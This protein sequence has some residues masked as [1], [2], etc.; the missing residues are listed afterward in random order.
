MLLN[1]CG[2]SSSYFHPD[3]FPTTRSDI[4][5]GSA[6]VSTEYPS[7]MASTSFISNGQVPFPAH[8]SSRLWPHSNVLNSTVTLP[9]STGL[10]HD[11]LSM[12]RRRP[13]KLQK[14]NRML[15]IT[16][17]AARHRPSSASLTVHGS[18]PNRNFAGKQEY[19]SSAFPSTFPVAMITSS[20]PP[21][22]HRKLTKK[23]SPQLPSVPNPSQSDVPPPVPPK[24]ISL[25]KNKNVTISMILPLHFPDRVFRN[26]PFLPFLFLPR[27]NLRQII[28]LTVQFLH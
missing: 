17:S 19:S 16:Q 12:D 3:H 5:H 4:G 26:H 9:V 10:R 27:P 13:R 14:T 21:R 1:S 28:A 18:S 8:A 25:L 6:V 22:P 15:S 24:P 23:P 7:G 2:S 20:Q 11:F